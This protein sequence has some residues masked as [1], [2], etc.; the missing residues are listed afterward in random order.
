MKTCHNIIRTLLTSPKFASA[1][2]T[3]FLGH[4][5]QGIDKSTDPVV[6]NRAAMTLSSPNA[7]TDTSVLGDLEK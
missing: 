3:N 4:M 6:P 1:Q 5:S 2:S 7:H